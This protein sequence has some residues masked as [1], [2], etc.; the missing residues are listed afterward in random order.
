M[1]PPPDID[2]MPRDI[3]GVPLR[4]EGALRGALCTAGAR[5]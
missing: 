1:P 3:D 2:G 5:I 4:I